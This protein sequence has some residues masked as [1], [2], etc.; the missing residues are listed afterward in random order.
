[1]PQNLKLFAY[2]NIDIPMVA[3]EVAIGR[4]KSICDNNPD[5]Y[6]ISIWQFNQ[7][8]NLSKLG[9]TSEIADE[10]RLEAFRQKFM[11]KKVSRLQ[12]VY[13]FESEEMAH[14]ALD[15]WGLSKYKKY[16]SQV[17][18]SANEISRYD[19]EWITTFKGKGESHWL[20]PYLAGETLGAAPLTEVLASGI[21]LVM[22]KDLRIEA[23]KRILEK[24]PTST[25][26]LYFAICG[27]G[28]ANIEDAALVRPFLL[29]KDNS[30]TGT[31][32]IQMASMRL[33]Q[34]EIAQAAEICKE[35]G[36]SLPIVLP[37][38]DDAFSTVPDFRGENFT[39]EIPNAQEAFSSI[40]HYE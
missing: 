17:N 7:L 9:E 30:I 26:F 27:F 24:W 8:R 34:A 38:G 15:R 4:V 33:H 18:F 5:S 28:E 20:E 37:K 31:F 2:L 19:S 16:I 6:G 25:P 39:L 32:I 22:N 23:Y 12:G 40:H 10:F 14:A 13:F 3:W 11:P 1:M 35:K 36:L 29:N 21:G